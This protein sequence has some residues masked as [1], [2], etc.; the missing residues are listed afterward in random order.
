MKQTTHIINWIVFLS[1]V[2]ILSSCKKEFLERTP[3]DSIVDASFYQTDEQVLAST[4]LL[5]SRVWFDYNDKALTT[6]AISGPEPLFRLI[7]TAATCCS[8]P[9][10]IIPKMQP[11]G[12]PSLS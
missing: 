12:V 8:I 5:Y 10:A 3:T 1:S 11:P 7:T 4:A 9:R 6:W 2:L